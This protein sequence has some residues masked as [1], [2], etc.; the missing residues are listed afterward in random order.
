MGAKEAKRTGLPERIAIP[1]TL[2]ISALGIVDD[3]RRCVSMD[4]KEVGNCLVLASASFRRDGLEA[5]RA[6][7]HRVAELIRT[8]KVRAAHDISDGGL[9]VT[10]AEMCIASSMGASVSVHRKALA[11]SIFASTAT[12]YLL[13]MKESILAN[14]AS[15][16]V[17]FHFHHRAR[18]FSFNRDW[19]YGIIGNQRTFRRIRNTYLRPSR[20]GQSFHPSPG[21]DCK[22][23]K[24]HNA[25]AIQIACKRPFAHAGLRRPAVSSHIEATTVWHPLS[26]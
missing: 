12:A 20:P 8:G 25:I 24:V 3:V 23:L 6:M 13:E 17:E 11:D 19:V 2:L 1:Y 9:A 22:I 5:A 7:H 21:K 10:V 14:L 16:G 4:L 18:R 26:R 15:I